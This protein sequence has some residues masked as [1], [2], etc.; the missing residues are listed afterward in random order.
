MD[1]GIKGLNY[2]LGKIESIDKVINNPD[3][4]SKLRNK[5]LET[6]SNSEL[7]PAELAYLSINKTIES[8]GIDPKDI[9]VVV[10]ASTSFWRKNF[11]TEYDIA[12]LMHT[13]KLENAFPIGIF[14]PGCANA[15]NALHVAVNLVKADN[16]KNVLVV[17]TDKVNPESNDYRLMKPDISILSDAASSFI[18]SCENDIDFKVDSIYHHSFPHMWNLDYEHDFVANLVATFKGS[19]IAIENILKKSSLDYSEIS[20]IF[21]NNYNIPVIEMIGKKCGFS[22]NQIYLNNVKKIAHAYAS[23]TL[24]NMKD[25]IDSINIGKNEHFLLLG[26]GHKNWAGTVLTKT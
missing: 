23:D 6:F 26:T 13:L 14:L 20:K 18:V 22:E 2:S 1:I 19:Q 21:M 25:H 12:W 17:T 10:Y 16:Y 3:L 7:T 9:E 11:Y 15:I 8:A 24:I 5:G 4:L